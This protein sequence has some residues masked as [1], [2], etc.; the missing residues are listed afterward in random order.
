MSRGYSELAWRALDEAVSA[1]RRNDGCRAILVFD[2]LDS[3]VPR[4]WLKL[5]DQHVRIVDWPQSI[6]FSRSLLRLKESGDLAC[7]GDW[8][9]A[10][11]A[12]DG[13]S[14]AQDIRRAMLQAG[15]TTVVTGCRGNM[16]IR[17][18]LKRLAARVFRFAIRGLFPSDLDVN[19]L[20]VF[21]TV[22][23]ERLPSSAGHATNLLMHEAAEEARMDRILF[24][25]TLAASSMRKLPRASNVFEVLVGLARA[26]VWRIRSYLREPF[27]V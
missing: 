3:G 26:R 22:L 20:T 12:G 25:A 11:V 21:P 16:E 7:G 8:S 13:S 9:Y 10:I 18:P 15:P 6:G 23:L 14:T 4:N 5:V 1:V 27:E 2:G 17:P 24:S 19:G